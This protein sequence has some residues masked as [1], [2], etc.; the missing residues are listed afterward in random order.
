MC[1]EGSLAS[2]RMN[3]YGRGSRTGT[4]RRGSGTSASI[5]I[6]R[7]GLRGHHTAEV[8]E[9]VEYAREQG[10]RVAVQASGHGHVWPQRRCADRDQE[11]QRST[12]DARQKDSLDR[13]RRDL[14]AGD[15]RDRTARTWALRG[16]GGNFGVVT[17]MEIDLFP[18]PTL[19]GGSLYYD[20]AATPGVLE[21]WHSWTQTVPESVTSAVGL[22][23]LRPPSPTPH[24]L[25]PHQP[26]PTE[27][28]DYRAAVTSI[29]TSW[30][31]KPSWATPSSVPA[32]LKA[33]A[34]GDSFSWV[35][36]AP[37]SSRSE[38]FT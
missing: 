17:A 15:R 7:R 24:P 4:T 5:R 26:P 9:A 27:P 13:G 36:T 33:G 19:Y 11:L 37:S 16:G 6:V 12:V 14:A 29:S 35:Q 10:K 38:L 18:V 1:P 32:D 31:V 28:R 34:S 22:R 8:Q 30:P 2:S 25:R 21:A 20:L 3:D 23:R